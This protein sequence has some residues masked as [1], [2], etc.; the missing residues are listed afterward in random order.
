MF[1][2][3]PTY[4]LPGGGGGGDDGGG[5]SRTDGQNP[6]A[7]AVI[8]FHLKDAPA[9]DAKSSLEILDANGAVVREYKSD[10]ETP[11]DKLE[12]EGRHEPRRLGPAL[13]R[14]RG[15]PGPDPLGQR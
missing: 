15:I 1:Q 12:R 7:G 2:P 6:P 14:R 13:R 9:K 4:R 8:R 10:A 3:R 5:P 11:G